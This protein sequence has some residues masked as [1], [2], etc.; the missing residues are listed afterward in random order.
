MRPED[1][2]GKETEMNLNEYFQNTEG[3]GVFSTADAGGRVDT[4]IYGIPH[5]MDEQ[6]VAFIMAERKQHENLKHNAHAAY[7]F[8]EKGDSYSGLRLYLTKVREEKN[9]ERIHT[10]MRRKNRTGNGDDKERN[11]YLVFFHVD[12]VLALTGSG[13]CPV[14]NEK[15]DVA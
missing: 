2:T 4:A 6:T 12:K 11:D 13:I 7:L 8:K 3:F 15:P 10:L 9:S 5:V 14:D 1:P